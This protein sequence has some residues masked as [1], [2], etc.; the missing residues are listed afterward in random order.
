MG[1]LTYPKVFQCDNS[2]E[3]KGEVIKLLEKHGVMIRHV[4]A[5]YYHTHTAFVKALNKLIAEQLFKVQDVQELNSPEKVSS[6]WVKH[7][8]GLVNQLNDME[9]QMTGMKPKDAIELKEVLLLS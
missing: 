9:T 7:L 4:T 1:P 8:Y 5:K 3:F 6:T 2:S